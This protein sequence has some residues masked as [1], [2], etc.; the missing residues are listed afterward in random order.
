[1]KYLIF[2][3]SGQTG[4]YL[5]QNLLL[6][7]H[8]VIGIA[9]TNFPYKIPN[10]P[11]FRQIIGNALEPHFLE[12]VIDEVD[13]DVVVNLLSLSSVSLCSE[14]SE[15][16][17]EVNY[18]FASR[19]FEETFKKSE[20]CSTPTRLLQASSSEMFGGYPSGTS[21]NENLDPN[22]VSVYGR[23]K[24]LAHLKLN[25]LKGVSE[26]L[27]STS[28]ILFNHESPRRGNRF[29]TRKIIDSIYEISLGERR[30]LHLGDLDVLRDWGYAKDF[31]EGIARIASIN[32]NQDYVV[33][34]GVLH[35]VGQFCEEAFRKFDVPIE[36]RR[37]ISDVSLMRNSNNNGLSAN[38]SKV[39]AEIGWAPKVEFL[40]LIEILVDTKLGRMR[41]S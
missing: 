38:T 34:T 23:H 32:T 1:M 30:E 9:R 22:P 25:E 12:R 24:T 2:G 7:G 18:I 17:Y 19:L 26:Y 13:F 21:I 8:E 4:S 27:Q 6:H 5:V 31:A 3:S 36:K 10:P 35:S 37:V 14:N 11:N 40:E 41:D 15:E 33:G 29:V 20:K 39:N 28:I 16:S